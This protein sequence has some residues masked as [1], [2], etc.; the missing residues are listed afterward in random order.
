MS[1]DVAYR[2][3]DGIGGKTSLHVWLLVAPPMMHDEPCDNK[4]ASVTIFIHFATS[5]DSSDRLLCNYEAC[6]VCERLAE[7]NI[8]TFCYCAYIIT[9]RYKARKANPRHGP[10]DQRALDQ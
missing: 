10:I 7:Q 4:T 3:T 9:Y 1:Y 6:T 2:R 8:A 5:L